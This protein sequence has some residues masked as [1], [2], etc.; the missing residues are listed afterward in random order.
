MPVKLRKRDILYIK[1]RG[2]YFDY[3]SKWSVG[4]YSRTLDTYFDFFGKYK[5]SVLDVWRF[6][7]VENFVSD[8]FQIRLSL[9]KNEHEFY[10]HYTISANN[11]LL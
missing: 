9:A 10:T 7:E 1:K 4:D 5:I 6:A 8:I 2:Q 11:Y 3:P